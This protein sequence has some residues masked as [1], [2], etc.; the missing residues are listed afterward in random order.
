MYSY[1]FY[2]I[3]NDMLFIMEQKNTKTNLKLI[4]SE[5]F[6]KFYMYSK[7]F[8]NFENVLQNFFSKLEILFTFKTGKTLT[9]INH[10]K[11]FSKAIEHKLYIEKEQNQFY[12]FVKYIYLKKKLKKNLPNFINYNLLKPNNSAVENA[13]GDFSLDFFLKFTNL[14]LIKCSKIILFG[15]TMIPVA[16]GALGSGML[17]GLFNIASSRNPDEGDKLYGN[18]LVAFALIETFIFLG[19][20]VSAA[21]TF[22]L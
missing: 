20:I 2:K 11:T 16:F 3:N 4:D 1:K 21:V 8:W 22:I 5:N 17:F 10:K 18:T 15:F 19:L 6:E 7:N 13:F 12:R 9:F 14:I